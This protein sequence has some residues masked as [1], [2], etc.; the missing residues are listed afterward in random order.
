MTPDVRNLHC[1][2][3][4]TGL[5]QE[6]LIHVGAKYSP[7]MRVDMNQEAALTFDKEMENQTACCIYNDGSGCVQSLEKDC[8]V[9]A[10]T[11]QEDCVLFLWQ[12]QYIYIFF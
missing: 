12:S 9:S 7:C 5:R 2:L 4:I 11:K 10:Y 6:D 3:I 1:T 8:S